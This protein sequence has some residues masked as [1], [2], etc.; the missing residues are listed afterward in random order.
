MSFFGFDT[1]LP[2]DRNN[3]GFFSN[4]DAFA[5]LSSGNAAGDD[6]EMYVTSVNTIA[7]LTDCII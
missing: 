4:Q 6:D 5:G 1:T 3:Q 7:A 2:R